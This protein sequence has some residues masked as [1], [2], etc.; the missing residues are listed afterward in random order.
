M[1][2]ESIDNTYT[3]IDSRKM[4]RSCSELTK[5]NGDS[6]FIYTN[7]IHAIGHE[8]VA[9]SKTDLNSTLT[10]CDTAPARY[11]DACLYGVFME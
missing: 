2:M 1:I 5:E 7:C 4:I 8:F 10:L 11:R 6:D 9:K 3:E